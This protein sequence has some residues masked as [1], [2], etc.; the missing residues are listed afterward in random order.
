MR[1]DTSAASGRNNSLNLS[2]DR[3][4]A[5]MDE[6]DAMSNRPNARRVHSRLGF[7]QQAID[8]EVIQPSGGSVGFCV[9]C[10]N[11]SRGGMSVL[12][13]AY[14]HV[15]TKCRVRLEHLR[16]GPQWIDAQVVQ[17]RHVTGRAHD[18]GLRFTQEVDVSNFIRIDP[19]DAHYSLERID[20]DK[21]EGRVLL[22]TASDID[23]KLIEVYVS[24]TNLRMVRVAEYEDALKEL[25]QPFNLVLCDFDRDPF[26]AAKVLQEMRNRGMPMPVVAIS[27]DKSEATR[28][29]IRDCFVNALIVKPVEKLT[30]LRALAEFIVLGRQVDN[31][32]Q[33]KP[34][35]DP[36]LKALAEIFADDLQK[37]AAELEQGVEKDD[38]KS[39]RYICAR[40]RGTGPLLGH[41]VVA[42]A[43][44][45]VLLLLDQEGSL[46]SAANS[47]K[48][49]VYL[50]RHAKNA[51]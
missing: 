41:A 47:V 9:A 5:L 13:S 28:Q 40:I 38:E 45:K 23:R 32:T 33:N 42:D 26:D 1:K 35:S 51:A 17:C 2:P 20:P 18:V 10:R 8:V 15:G 7:R 50:C 30:L 6:L 21:L 4:H 3:L 34:Q 27:G 22:I 14:M 43:A 39:V 11:I 29:I 44:N 24:E 37:F 48:S 36:S 49:L 12:H 16:D 25:Q 31:K 19:L 46:A